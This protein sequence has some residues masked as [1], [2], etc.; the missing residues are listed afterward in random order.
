MYLSFWTL[1]GGR[2]DFMIFSFKLNFLLHLGIYKIR[3][4]F[5]VYFNDAT[6]QPIISRSEKYQRHLRF[7]KPD[8][9]AN[10]VTLPCF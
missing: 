8:K 5:D 3:C 4:G 1:R 6:S 7:D 10:C 2:Q 9:F